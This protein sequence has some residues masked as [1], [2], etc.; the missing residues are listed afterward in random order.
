MIINIIIIIIIIILLL[1]GFSLQCLLMVFHWSLCDSKSPQVYRTPLSIL[2]D[3]TNAVVWMFS[4]C[5]F[6]CKSYNLFT[7][8]L[9]SVLDVPITIGITVN[10][11]FIIITI[12]TNL[13]NQLLETIKQFANK[14]LSFNCYGYLNAY[15]CIH[16]KHGWLLTGILQAVALPVQL[17]SCT[18]K[19]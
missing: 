12:L 7:N 15:I 10:F 3:L 2:V 1:W 5:P 17:Y 18:K 16:I 19:T 11:M 13:L 8:Y 6:I 9:R 4:T 14:W